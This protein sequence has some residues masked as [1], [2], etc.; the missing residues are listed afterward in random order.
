LY[1]GTNDTLQKMNYPC[2]DPETGDGMAALP[3]ERATVPPDAGRV[4]APGTGVLI[5]VRGSCPGTK[6]E[7]VGERIVMGRHSSCQIVLDNAAVSRTH[8]L[9]VQEQGRYY[10]EDLRSR[11]GTLLNG[12]KIQ[13]RTELRDNDEIRVCEVVLKF[14]QTAPPDTYA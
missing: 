10:I 9:I 3:P 2:V 12:R 1:V 5:V 14:Y 6:I 7:L 4:G 8:T 13:G 11:N